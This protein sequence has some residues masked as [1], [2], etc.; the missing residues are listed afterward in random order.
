MKVRDPFPRVNSRLLQLAW[1]F[2]S[3]TSINSLK[4]RKRKGKMRIGSDDY[5][6]LFIY[7][8][9]SIFM[10]FMFHRKQCSPWILVIDEED[11]ILFI[12]PFG[13]KLHPTMCRTIRITYYTIRT[14]GLDLDWT[15]VGSPESNEPADSEETNWFNWIEFFFFIKKTEK[16]Q[17]QNN[18]VL[19]CI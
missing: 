7:L 19:E 15:G 1:A 3:L 17:H 12:F 2:F 9:L 16:K 6:I 10:I 14:I 8:F 13:I 11:N 4:G 5:F 18:V